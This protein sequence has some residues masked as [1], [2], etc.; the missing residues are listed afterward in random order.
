MQKT[1]NFLTIVIL[2]LLVAGCSNPKGY[3]VGSLSEEQKK[4]LGEKLTAEE[5][6]MLTAWMMRQAF[7]EQKIPPETTIEDAL[8]DQAQWLAEQKV[9]EAE[10]KSLADRVEKE[11]QQKRA[12]FAKLVS[13]VVLSKR[14]IDADYGQKG[15]VFD[16]AFENKGDKDIEGVKGVLHIQDIFGDE[17]MNI[18]WSFDQG[19]KAGASSVE[20]GSG[21]DI[22][23]FMDRHMKLWN[24]DFS[25]MKTSFE[26]STIV[27][28]D[29]TS[30]KAPE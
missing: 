17:I 26:V 15:V 24:T 7:S 14:N 16:V 28:A 8:A 18:N 4:E 12:E 2:A 25:K 20:R 29:G 22:N 1:R 19:I 3:K 23:Q 10:A 5:G 9:K 21:M 6:Q 30:L 27:F 13:V 11:R